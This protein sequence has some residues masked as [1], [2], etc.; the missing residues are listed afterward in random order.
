MM[1]VMRFKQLLLFLS[2]LVFLLGCTPQRA[3]DIPVAGNDDDSAVDDEEPTPMPKDLHGT[4]PANPRPL[5]KFAARNY[6]GAQRGPDNLR[7]QPTVLWF[8]PFAGT[9]L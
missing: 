9:P 6:D 7:G 2:T 3:D 1:R 4:P 5:P 8:F